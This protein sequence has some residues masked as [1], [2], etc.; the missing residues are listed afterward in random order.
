[1]KAITSK[2]F[3]VVVAEFLEVLE[4]FIDVC[5]DDE[6]RRCEILQS[7]KDF[8]TKRTRLTSS[9]VLEAGFVSLETLREGQGYDLGKPKI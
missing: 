7:E 4:Y 1:M 2:C 6:V 8:I 9:C 5:D 3:I